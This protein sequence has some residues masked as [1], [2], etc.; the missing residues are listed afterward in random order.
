MDAQNVG[1]RHLVAFR[2]DWPAMYLTDEGWVS[3]NATDC[4]SNPIDVLNFCKKVYPTSD[5]RN[6]V[7]FDR[8]LTIRNWCDFDGRDCVQPFQVKPFRCLIGSFVA[9]NLTVLDGCVSQQIV[10]SRVCKSFRSWE[11]RAARACNRCRLRIEKRSVLDPCDVGQFGGI[12]F[13]CCPFNGAASEAVGRWPASISDMRSVNTPSDVVTNTTTADVVSENEHRRYLRVKTELHRQHDEQ[14]TK[15]MDAWDEA[16][17]EVRRMRRRDPEMAE[18]LERKMTA[19]FQK[20]ISS[21]EE[22]EEGERRRADANHERSIQLE[23]N[24]KKSESMQAYMAI[25]SH[26]P[27]ASMRDIFQALRHYVR[28]E[29]KDRTHVINHFIRLGESDAPAAE[30]IRALV[31]ERLLSIQLRLKR[32]LDMLSRV[33]EYRPVVTQKIK[34]IIEEYGGF[35]DLEA[36]IVDVSVNETLS[37]REMT[38]NDNEQLTTDDEDDEEMDKKNNEEDDSL[39]LSHSVSET[40][41]RRRNTTGN[42]AEEDF[43]VSDKSGRKALEDDGTVEVNPKVHPS[44]HGNNGILLSEKK[45]FKL[46]HKVGTSVGPLVLV[47]A[48][49]IF[50][51]TV[52]I[53]G[54]VVWR[55]YV[56]TRRTE[57]RLRDDS[58][59]LMSPEQV[60][61]AKMQANGYENPTY[62]YF[63]EKTND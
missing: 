62:K 42:D 15:I 3:D 45:S 55:R 48:T 4:L 58:C 5:V 51:V 43:A 60:H 2:C 44:L 22:R 40:V 10:D 13:V 39:H 50:L 24:R 57:S 61:V 47:V 11:T 52:T 27:Q 16:Q 30:S 33:S 18:K 36:S 23:L 63:E 25:L 46:N 12:Q 35:D 28:L 31:A 37:R 21:L 14:M 9:G 34:D 49:S 56:E 32:A 59:L 6:I 29:E 38:T 41:D 26:Q 20:T 53:L 7:E 19:R 1:D 54:V 8:S 17:Q